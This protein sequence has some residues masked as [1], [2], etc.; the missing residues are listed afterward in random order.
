M[1]LEPNISALH[2]LYSISQADDYV[3]YTC[4]NKSSETLS[5]LPGITLQLTSKTWIQI[6]ICVTPSFLSSLLGITDSL[7]IHS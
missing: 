3:F 6:C 7:F 1:Y 5:N 4:G 2:I